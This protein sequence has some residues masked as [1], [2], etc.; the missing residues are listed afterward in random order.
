MVQTQAS[1]I[2]D[3]KEFKRR[4]SKKMKVQQ[5][6]LYGSRAR[7]DFLNQSDVDLIIISN[8][9]KDVPFLERTYQASKLWRWNLPLEVF[10]Y[11]PEE[12]ESKKKENTY[13]QKILHEAV[14]I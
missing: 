6:I 9:F 11:T 2:K 4:L 5:L 8:G 7:G 13:L 12:F 3:I 14:F 10:C 1:V